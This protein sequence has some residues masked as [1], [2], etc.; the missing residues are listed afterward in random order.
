MAASLV[1]AAAFLFEA[2]MTGSIKKIVADRG[3]GF[4]NS[5]QGEVFFHR[6]VLANASFESLQPGQQVEFEAE[7]GPKGL[8]ATSVRLPNP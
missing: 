7:R 5:D 4:I 8:R 3:F 1:W 6:S 2:N